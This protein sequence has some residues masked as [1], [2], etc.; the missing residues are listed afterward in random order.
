MNQPTV[1]MQLPLNTEI[2]HWGYHMGRE[3]RRLFFVDITRIR[4]RGVG[5]PQYP[6]AGDWY[7]MRE[8]FGFCW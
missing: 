2:S 7:Q 1:Q 3:A 5:L 8:T 4:A 6:G